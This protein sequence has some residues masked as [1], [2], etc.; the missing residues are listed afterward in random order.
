MLLP[1]IL[2]GVPVLN[3][4]SFMP[5]LD[6]LADSFSAFENQFGPQ[7]VVQFPTIILLLRYTPVAKTT[8]FAQ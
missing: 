1:F 3:R 6:K 4:R 2:A 5:R 7:F 8:V